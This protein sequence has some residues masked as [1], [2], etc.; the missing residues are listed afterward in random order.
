MW[1]RRILY[2]LALGCALLGQLLDVGYLFHYIFYLTLT[3]PL[4]GLLV[5]LPAMLSCRAELTAPSGQVRRGEEARWRLTFTSRLALPAAQVSCRVGLRGGFGGKTVRVRKKIRG[6]Y[7]GKRIVWSVDTGH[8]DL[9]AC[10]VDRLWVW[11]CLGLFALPVPA[12]AALALPVCP[13]PE[14]PGP[15]RLPEDAGA[16]EAVPRGKSPAGEDYELRPYRPGDPPRTIHW[17]MSAKRDE[18]ITRE[19]L[20]VRRPLPVLTIDLFGPPEA[21]DRTLDRLAGYSQALLDQERPHEI[22]W[23]HPETGAARRR[24][25]SCQREWLAC[26]TAILSDPAPLRGRSI[27]ESPLAAEGDGPVCPIHISGEE[28][29]HEA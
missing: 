11:D 20:S 18:P 17:K 25:V 13:I 12:P 2:A 23:V 5:S 14:P 19:L 28:A 6:V 8:C 9:P 29:S 24:A 22:R 1:R 4:L 26:L 10:R 7:P 21:L 3:L 15:L 27:L 16:P